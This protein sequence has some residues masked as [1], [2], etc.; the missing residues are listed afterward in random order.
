MCLVFKMTRP[1]SCC[2]DCHAKDVI[3]WSTA[4]LTAERRVGDSVDEL[5]S[6]ALEA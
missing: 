6:D 4:S 2:L 1:N 3:F 5:G